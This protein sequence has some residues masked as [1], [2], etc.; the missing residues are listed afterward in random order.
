MQLDTEATETGQEYTEC[1]EENRK[2]EMISILVSRP[3]R[4]A[5]TQVSLCDLLPSLLR[6]CDLF[7]LPFLDSIG[8][9]HEVPRDG[10][11]SGK[12]N[13]LS[14]LRPCTG[15]NCGS[16]VRAPIASLRLRAL[17]GSRRSARR[18]RPRRAGAC[19]PASSRRSSPRRRRPRTSARGGNAGAAACRSRLRS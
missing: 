7:E 15:N 2:P 14:K 3:D 16:E 17:C 9:G 11:A 10:P 1:S 6:L 8:V 19:S 4:I 12:P 13:G 18:N 5:N